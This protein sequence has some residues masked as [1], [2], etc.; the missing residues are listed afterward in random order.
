MKD[1]RDHNFEFCKKAAS[2]SKE[3]LLD[4]LKPVEVQ[5]SSLSHDVEEITT[6]KQEVVAQGVSVANTIQ[7]SFKNLHA[8]LD[9]REQEL[10]K[11][12]ERRVQDKVDKLSKQVKS[13]SLLH[14]EVQGIV[15]CTERCVQHCADNE[16]MSKYWDKEDNR[17]RNGTI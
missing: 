1:H 14:A 13:L 10:L 4:E 16:V 2:S 9:M 17:T 11:E 8:I 6:T 3:K 7:I 5:V 12:A 15:D